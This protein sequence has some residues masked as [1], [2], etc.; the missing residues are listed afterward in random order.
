MSDETL[1]TKIIN[2]QLPS[3]MVFQDDTVTAFRDIHPRTPS[4]ILIVPNKPIPGS[5]DVSAEDETVLGH[6]MIVAAKIAASEGIADSGYRLI[7]NCGPDGHQEVPHLHMHM[8][9][10]RDLGRMVNPA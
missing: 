9:G 3:D 8:L 2:K 10:G 1:F 7:I 4:H 6:M 5:N